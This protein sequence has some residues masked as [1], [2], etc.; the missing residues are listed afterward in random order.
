MDEQVIVLFCWR[1][2]VKILKRDKKRRMSFKTH[3]F[4]TAFT[5][6][7]LPDMRESRMCRAEY[8]EPVIKLTMKRVWRNKE[9]MIKW[10]RKLVQAENKLCASWKAGGGKT[11]VTVTESHK[12]H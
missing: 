9:T 5:N 11:Q 6:V 10:G 1:K 7:M 3:T 8:S 4:K 2:A 12:E